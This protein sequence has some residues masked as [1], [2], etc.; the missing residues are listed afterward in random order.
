VSLCFIF[1]W[2]LRVRGTLKLEWNNSSLA[3]F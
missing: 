3:S 2:V 1:S